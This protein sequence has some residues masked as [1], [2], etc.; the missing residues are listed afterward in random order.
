MA[1]RRTALRAR[2]SGGH[3]SETTDRKQGN[4]LPVGPWHPRMALTWPLIALTGCHVRRSDITTKSHLRLV[5]R[6]A[7]DT[8]RRN[9]HA[10]DQAQVTV[11]RTLVR[12]PEFP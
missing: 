9:R 1:S 11:L 7:L 12:Y 4:A 6:L 3:A 2:P 10:S 5:P 8:R